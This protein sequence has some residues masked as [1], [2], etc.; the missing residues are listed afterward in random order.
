MRFLTYLTAFLFVFNISSAQD[1]GP[2][3]VLVEGG[4]FYMGNDYSANSDERPEHKVTLNSFFMSKY[5]V[6]VAEYANFCRVT[7]H[8]LPDGEERSP[9]NNITWEDAVMYCNWLSRASRL[10]KC[11]D[12]KRD[13]NRFTAIFIPGANGYRLPT[14]AE[15]EYAARGGMKS[16]AYAFSGSHDLDEVAWSINNSGN[17]SHEIGQ[18]K[19]NEL[20]IYDM[21]GNAME[22]C[23]DWYE[24]DY[25]ENSPADNPSG[26]G[27]GVSKVCRGGNF[28]CRPDVLR[29]SRRFNLE[30]SQEEGLA[31]I[32]LVKNQ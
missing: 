12:L 15:W 28:M 6:T 26:P 7:G 5:E 32:R 31:G 21:T 11:Y 19:P 25:Y 8:K 10:E 17:T 9:I 29:N 20:G 4:D 2:E 27:T 24:V 16:K 30:P 1:Q 3:M 22:W 14:E 18:K 23:Y 13:S